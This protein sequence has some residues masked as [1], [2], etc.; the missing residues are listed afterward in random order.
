MKFISSSRSTVFVAVAMALMLLASM[1]TAA[2]A[3][4]AATITT[5]SDIDEGST[6]NIVDADSET[7]ST[8]EMA[9]AT[10]DTIESAQVEITHADRGTT[11]YE[12]DLDSS[13]Y[14][15]VEEDNADSE[16]VHAWTISH[17][18][19]ADVP[20]AVNENATMTATI[21]VADSDGETETSVSFDLQNGNQRSVV[22]VGSSSVD[23]DTVGAEVETTVDEVGTLQA[24]YPLS[25]AEDEDVY[26]IEDERTVSNYTDADGNTHLSTIEVQPGESG[27]EDAL[28]ASAEDAEAGDLLHDQ[29]ALVDGEPVFM[30]ADEADTDLVD[31]DTD[32]YAIYDTEA[33]M[34][35]YELG[36]E[37]AD[38]DTVT[39]YAGTH[40]VLYDGDYVD[41]SSAADLFGDLSYSE[42]RD[43]GFGPI[44]TIS[45]LGVWPFGV[46]GTVSTGLL[47]IGVVGYTR[48]RPA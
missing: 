26:H 15:L 11:H 20:V 4:T 16:D 21:T 8:L 27:Y 42:L 1:G 37:Y 17:D 6:V 33:G 12:A 35:E 29:S 25:D 41:T 14:E 9:T 39:V 7:T 31:T 10:A 24:Y 5:N 44:E 32:T 2:A 48:R 23:N 38:G 18:E 28:A 22:Y 13:D 30:F 36:D 45:S 3:P 46:F 47:S 43:V 34:I 19:F 40:D